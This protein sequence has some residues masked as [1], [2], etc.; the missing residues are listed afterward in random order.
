MIRALI[1]DMD[2][3]LVNSEKLHFEAWRKILAQ[4]GVDDFPLAAF[5]R[6]VGVSNERLAGD[7]IRSHRLPAD[8]DTLVREK[9]GLYLKMIPAIEPMPGVRETVARYHG[10]CLLAVASSSD[11]IELDAILATLGLAACFDEV[12]GGDMVSRKKPDPEIYLRTMS[13][14]GV[15]PEE[16]IAFEDSEAGIAAVK[17]AGMFG[18]AVPSPLLH[19]GDFSRADT[20]IPR[21]DLADD[22][23]LQDLSGRPVPQVAGCTTGTSRKHNRK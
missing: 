20:V 4:H 15:R 8:I 14:L 1:F 7:Y 3:T 23:L 5:H 9:Q 18:I 11:R 17:N 6:Y 19:D 16:C 21:I 13:L 2:G 10:R 12:V 22:R